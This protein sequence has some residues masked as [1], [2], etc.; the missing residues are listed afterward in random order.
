[1]TMNY[2]LIIFIRFGYRFIQDD[3][4]IYTFYKAIYLVAYK[5]N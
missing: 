3:H 2:T 1:M 4:K 5:R